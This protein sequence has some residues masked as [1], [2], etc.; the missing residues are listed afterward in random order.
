MLKFHDDLHIVGIDASYTDEKEDMISI[1]FNNKISWVVPKKYLSLFLL[2]SSTN[3][4]ELIYDLMTDYDSFRTDYC[5]KFLGKTMSEGI[6]EEVHEQDSGL[7]NKASKT[8]IIITDCDGLAITI[9]QAL[10]LLGYDV[11]ILDKNHDVISS[12]LVKESLFL[13]KT[14]VGQKKSDVISGLKCKYR[15]AKVVDC[16]DG[17]DILN[18]DIIINTQVSNFTENLNVPVINSWDYSK[19]AV[20]NRMFSDADVDDAVKPMIN[21]L[22]IAIE[23]CKDV[24]NCVLQGTVF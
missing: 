1:Y 3:S 8:K 2:Y 16:I 4:T 11:T 15:F 19:L 13:G 12:E 23:V 24:A 21:S 6:F 5:Y 17:K 9:S 22:L 14:N 7:L 18:Y 10:L 20:N